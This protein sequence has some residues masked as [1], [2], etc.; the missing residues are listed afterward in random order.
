VVFGGLPLFVRVAGKEEQYE[1]P[2]GIDDRHAIDR[3]RNRPASATQPL[4]KIKLVPDRRV[5]LPAAA[6]SQHEF[7]A[8][9]PHFPMAF[10]LALI[11]DTSSGMMPTI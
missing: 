6:H 5:G 2:A 3:R 4:K 7:V 9:P 8:A 1:N 10:P 11:G